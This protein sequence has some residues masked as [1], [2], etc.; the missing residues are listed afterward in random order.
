MKRNTIQLKRREERRIQAGHLWIYSNEIDT[1]K[2]PLSQFTKGE[3]A[4]VIASD[5][6]FLGIAY[7]NP[8]SL[9]TGRLLSR[10]RE[11]FDQKQLVQRLEAALA[12]RNR[13]FDKPYYRMVYG[14]SDLLPGLIVDRFGDHLSVQLNSA[15]MDVLK[16]RVLD[17]LRKV[18]NPASI[19]LRNDSSVRKL[20]QLPLAIEAGFGDPPTEVE[21]I[22]NDVKMTVPLRHGQKTGWFYDQRVNRA[23]LSKYV[24]GKRVL[25]VFC[26]VGSFAIQCA[27]AG[28]EEVW[29]VDASRSA[30]ENAL[31]NGAQNG[32]E[33]RFYSVLGDAFEVLRALREE[34]EYFDVIVV[35]PPAFIKRKKDHVKGLRAYQRI[36]ELAMRLLAPDGIL[37][38]ASCSMHL[39]RA[40]LLDVIR[41]GS[42]KTGRHSQLLFEGMQGPDH[43]VHPA[44]PETR[45][46][47]AYLARVYKP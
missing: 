39:K 11:H 47:K 4:E 3:M 31:E 15:G 20:E 35:D 21:V 38:A 45:Y 22:E 10:R 19:L 43:P 30:L 27:V 13:L 2:T 24:R 12:L 26:Y 1:K 41:S 42:V 33:N 36:G 40:E 17:G 28:A 16:E 9:I 23:E 44:I 6:K 34:G 18:V 7:L 46:L 5:G 37:M 14:E 8:H 29:G 25:D 32:V